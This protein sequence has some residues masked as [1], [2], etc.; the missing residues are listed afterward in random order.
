MQ[1]QYLDVKRCLYRYCVTQKDVADKMGITQA[2][3]SQ[4]INLNPTINFLGRMAKAIGCDIKDLL[5]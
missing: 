5:K 2:T 4:A 1:N 3:L